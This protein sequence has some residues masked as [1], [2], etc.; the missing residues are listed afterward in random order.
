MRQGCAARDLPRGETRLSPD[1]LAPCTSRVVVPVYSQSQHRAP[2]TLA[3]LVGARVVPAATRLG[4][5]LLECGKLV[6]LLCNRI[7]ET[8]V[9]NN[10][11]PKHH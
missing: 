2:C 10:L 6:N 4:L 3:L 1:T 9:G 7:S 8:D 5:G 11:L